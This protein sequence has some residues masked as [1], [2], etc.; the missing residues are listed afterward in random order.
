MIESI[1]PLLALLAGVY[2]IAAVADAMLG[3]PRTRSGQFAPHRTTSIETGFK[4]ACFL[5][6]GIVLL[7]L[8]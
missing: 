5:S 1:V 7:I 4:L 6:L 8:L 2:L 3:Q